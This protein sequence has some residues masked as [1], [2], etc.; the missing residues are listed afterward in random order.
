M[1]TGNELD[2]YTAERET[3]W[4]ARLEVRA[5]TFLLAPEV[6][7]KGRLAFLLQAARG[8]ALLELKTGQVRL[9]F[10]GLVSQSDQVS[11]SPSAGSRAPDEAD[12]TSAQY[13]L[14]ACRRSNC[15]ESRRAA[16]GVLPQISTPEVGRS[17]RWTM[18]R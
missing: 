16:L 12:S 14:T 11:S 1:I 3:L 6:G 15:I 9:S 4:D 13:S 2:V 17:S 8:G 7:L 18:P 10:A 5:E